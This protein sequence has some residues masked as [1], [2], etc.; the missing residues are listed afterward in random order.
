VVNSFLWQQ[1][2]RVQV[3]EKRPVGPQHVLGKGTGLK[4]RITDADIQA[5]T[6]TAGSRWR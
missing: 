5:F 6:C 3:A 1:L 2:Q 4:G